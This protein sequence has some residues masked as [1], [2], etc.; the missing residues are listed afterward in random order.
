MVPMISLF[1][2]VLLAAGLVFVVSSVV[3]M[4]LPHHKT[5]FKGLPDEQAVLD[6]LGEVPP[7]AYDFPHVASWDEAKTPEMKA[8]FE[9]G[10]V[11]F[12]T[13]APGAP[14]MG[15]NLATWFVYCLVVSWIVCY[16]ATRTLQPGAEYLLVFQIT[17]TVAWAAYGLSA[18]SDSVWFS[19]PWSQ[20]FKLLFDALLYGLVTGGAFGWL[21]PS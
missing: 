1:W 13:V 5:D 17:C 7:G 10:P 14:N 2:A 19:R 6:A 9:K 4:V 15:K 8:R 3:W 20:T 11:G 16:V 12:F 21:W 18:V